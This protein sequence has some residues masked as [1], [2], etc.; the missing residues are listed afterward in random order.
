MWL[1]TPRHPQRLRK[2]HADIHDC[3]TKA[4]ESRP[5]GNPIQSHLYWTKTIDIASRCLTGPREF[6]WTPTARVCECIY[7]PDSNFRSQMP[8][9]LMHTAR[10]VGRSDCLSDWCLCGPF[11]MIGP[12]QTVQHIRP[13]RDETAVEP[14]SVSSHLILIPVLDG[15]TG[16]FGELVQIYG[17]VTPPSTPWYSLA[18]ATKH[19]HRH[20]QRETLQK[21]SSGSKQLGTL[22]FFTSGI[23]WAPGFTNH[24]L[25]SCLCISSVITGTSAAEGISPLF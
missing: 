24:H 19:G 11:T 1:E 20:L 3:I 10:L 16:P 4:L 12:R 5:H 14:N 8:R 21:A 18:L 23:V 9:W 13:H 17:Q 7:S 22:W 2:I 6:T 15:I 25:I